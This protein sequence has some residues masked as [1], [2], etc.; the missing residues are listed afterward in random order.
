MPVPIVTIATN[1]RPQ[2]TSAQTG[3]AE[4]NLYAAD[5]GSL[6]LFVTEYAYK[7]GRHSSQC[8]RVTL[9]REA[10]L[11]LKTALEKFFE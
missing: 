6:S 10:A 9:D 1:E 7:P 5:S 2:F 3:A 4:L 11:K 8:T